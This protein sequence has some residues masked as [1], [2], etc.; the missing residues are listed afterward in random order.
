MPEN[1]DV[2][3]KLQFL[4]LAE[5][6][7]YTLS[8]VAFGSV[9]CIIHCWFLVNHLVVQATRLVFWEARVS[10]VSGNTTFSEP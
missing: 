3:G 8:T 7:R 9:A 10:E 1:I 5:G 6:S 4:Q 2:F